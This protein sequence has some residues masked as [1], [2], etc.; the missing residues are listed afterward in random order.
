[1]K[2][3]TLYHFKTWTSAQKSSVEHWHNQQ[4]C[5]ACTHKRWVLGKSCIQNCKLTH[6]NVNGVCPPCNDLIRKSLLN[7]QEFHARPGILFCFLFPKGASSWIPASQI[8]QCI[9]LIICEFRKKQQFIWYHQWN[10][11]SHAII[12]LLLRDSPLYTPLVRP[13]LE[14]CIQPGVT[15]RGKPWTCQSKSTVGPKGWSYGWSTSPVKK[16]WD[17]GLHPGEGSRETLMKSFN[18]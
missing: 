8:F 7:W 16:G 18:I 10:L 3:L 11:P 9:C 15:S 13:H 6:F 2:I 14:C 12:D 4:H 17:S 1:M 5:T